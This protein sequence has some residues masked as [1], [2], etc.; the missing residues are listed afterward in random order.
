M[1]SVTL[2][3]ILAALLV[4]NRANLRAKHDKQT[5]KPNQVL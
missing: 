4:I 2:L 3:L 1:L 5:K